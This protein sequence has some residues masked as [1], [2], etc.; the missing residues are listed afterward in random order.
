MLRRFPM[1]AVFSLSLV[2]VILVG[3]L[4]EEVIAVGRA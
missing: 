3:L 1:P 4:L 2:V